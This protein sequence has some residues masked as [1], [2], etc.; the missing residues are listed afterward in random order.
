MASA[1]GQI[2][3]LRQI[4][5]EK[6]ELLQV[7]TERLELAAEQLDRLR[8]QGGTLEP[9]AQAPVAVKSGPMNDPEIIPDLRQMLTEW[10]DLQTRDW[11]GSLS[12]RLD[13]LHDLVAQLKSA[14]VRQPVEEV[15]PASVADILS[16]YSAN[17]TPVAESVAPAEAVDQQQIRDCDAPATELVLP[18]RPEPIDIDCGSTEELR[19]GLRHREDYIARLHDYLM[20]FDALTNSPIEGLTLDSLSAEQRETVEAWE[21]KVRKELRQTQI[22]LWVER[23]QLSREQMQLQQLQHHLETESKR[24]GINT[25]KVV[26]GSPAGV[27]AGAADGQKSKNWL[28]LFGG[29]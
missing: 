20:A 13:G 7:L 9:T 26:P 2:R 28:G 15:R 16:K 4:V 6:D 24:L 19:E 25:S 29:K 23:A 11:F 22:Q 5:L 8:R 12:D 1:D 3:E 18:E 21:A 14:P 17:S 10:G 27:G